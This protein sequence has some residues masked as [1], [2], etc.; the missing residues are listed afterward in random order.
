MPESI[1]SLNNKLLQCT[2]LHNDS[3]LKRG[4]LDEWYR[5]NYLNLA[6]AIQQEPGLKLII[7]VSSFDTLEKY[8]KKLFLLSDT[9]IVRDAI[10][11]PPAEKSPA[12]IPALNSLYQTSENIDIDHL[13]PIL[14]APP[15]H[16][17]TYW[18]SSIVKLKN[19]IN[20]PT[21]FKF[22][23]YF[24]KQFYDWALTS[25]RKLLETGQIVYAPFIPSFEIEYEF[26][27]KG[28]SIP[29][30]FNAQS[31][32]FRDYNWLNETHLISLL[33]LR[34]PTIENID[35]NTMSKIKKDNYDIYKKFSTELIS[36]IESIKSQVGTEDWAKE[37]RYIQKNKI[38]DNID[39]IN[40]EL[41]KIG[42]MRTLRKIGYAIGLLGLDISTGNILSSLC[43]MT[44][45]IISQGVTEAIKQLAETNKLQE[46][47]YY[48]LWKVTDLTKK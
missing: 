13:P 40:S 21:A 16:T 17:C 42:N 43:S 2:D 39:K 31:C 15:G 44:K 23:S 24:P 20:V 35:I 4:L 27:S 11:R 45:S 19:G 38:D 30:S 32:Y 33:S 29:Q 6:D 14:I 7:D 3:E 34:L 18:T 1:K 8:S 25:G 5:I 36:S 10:T 22:I 26:M 37:M 28:F 47:P 46:N 48:F 9:I 12:L 41:K